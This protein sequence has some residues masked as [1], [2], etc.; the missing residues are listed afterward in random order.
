MKF[1]K[2]L[3]SLKP[4]AFRLGG[5]GA[6]SFVGYFYL[7]TYS[8]LIVW[9]SHCV[10]SGVQTELKTTLAF[11]LLHLFDRHVFVCVCVRVWDTENETERAGILLDGLT[12][13]QTHLHAIPGMVRQRFRQTRDAVVT[14]SQD[15]DSH[16]FV[17]LKEDK[18]WN[19]KC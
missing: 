13:I 11:L 8:G 7:F 1:I 16:T 3:L 15:L 2:R 6:S 19:R 10:Y 17:F 5:G 12:H 4:K 14:I 9:D 18:R